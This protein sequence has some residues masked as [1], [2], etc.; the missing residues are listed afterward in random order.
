MNGELQV[1]RA[2]TQCR[3]RSD[4]FIPFVSVSQLL[5]PADRSVFT[6]QPAT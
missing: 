3:F 2:R 5:L 4:Q 6:A 1:R